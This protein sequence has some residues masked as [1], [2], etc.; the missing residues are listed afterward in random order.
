[1]KLEGRW[2]MVIKIKTNN[3]RGMLIR[4]FLGTNDDD[5]EKINP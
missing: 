5:S 3:E 4:S 2:E 1:M